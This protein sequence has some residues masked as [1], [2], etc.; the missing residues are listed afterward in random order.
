M[1]VFPMYQHYFVFVF[2]NNS[3]TINRLRAFFV[4][5]SV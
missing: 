4:A 5:M 2:A 3:N 1:R